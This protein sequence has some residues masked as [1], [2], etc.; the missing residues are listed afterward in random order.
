[1]TEPTAPIRA[2][3]PANMPYPHPDAPD[4]LAE[5]RARILERER[6]FEAALR[7]TRDS[8]SDRPAG[9]I[10]YRPQVA[11][12]RR[13]IDE[14]GSNPPPDVI[15]YRLNDR[16]VAINTAPAEDLRLAFHHVYADVAA[17]GRALTLLASRQKDLADRYAN[18]LLENARLNGQLLQQGRDHA[19]VLA[20]A[21]VRAIRW[22]RHAGMAIALASALG[23]VVALL[24]L[25]TTIQFPR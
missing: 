19:E 4:P 22:A 3:D 6:E 16:D 2:A 5:T 17:K 23:I 1:M 8:Y 15:I 12:D 20:R 14:N 7:A 11:D 10:L 21:Q 25:N 13:L 24:A 9:R 18:I